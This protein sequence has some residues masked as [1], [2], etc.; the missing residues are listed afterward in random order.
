MPLM[1]P[2]TIL[3]P[4]NYSDDSQAALRYAAALARLYAARLVVL[5]VADTPGPEK[6]TYGEIA[7]QRQPE[8]YRQR[9]WT[10]F[11][12]RLRLASELE[13]AELVLREGDAVDAIVRTAT[14]WGCGL[15]VM[16]GHE[17][18]GW[19]SLLFRRTEE[20]V[21]AQAPCPVLIVRPAAARATCPGLCS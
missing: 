14:E 10:E 4:T 9:L 11:R 21:L 8:G 6:V 7:A 5:Q 15:I 20:K 12:R 2:E 17:R 13:D 16:A 3:H 1:D 19:E 18:L